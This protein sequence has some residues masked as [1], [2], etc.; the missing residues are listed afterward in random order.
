MECFDIYY[1]LTITVTKVT[2]LRQK[3]NFPVSLVLMFCVAPS[4]LFLY[5][6]HCSHTSLK[7]FH[8]SFFF[9]GQYIQYKHLNYNTYNNE[10][11]IAVTTTV[12][13]LWRDN[14]RAVYVCTC[15]M[16]N[17]CIVMDYYALVSYD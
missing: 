9:K 16:F 13:V 17:T 7:V 15:K 11:T 12:V 4:K 14:G 8:K 10:G 3:A 5:S 1:Y 2:V 6:R